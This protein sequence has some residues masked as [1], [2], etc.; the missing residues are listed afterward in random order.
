MQQQYTPISAFCACAPP[1]RSLLDQWERHLRLL[2]QAGRITVWSE[3]HL[4]AGMVRS[5]EID[6]HLEQADLILLLLSADFFA[7]D[8]CIALMERALHLHQAGKVHV[9]P[10]LLRSVEW[11]E[12]PLASLS[13]LPSNG[14]PIIEW[15]YPDAAFRACVRGILHVLGRPMTSALQN[16]NRTRMLRRLRRSYSDLLSQS[17]QGAA[18]MKL[19]L[20]QKPN[21]V[22]NT[23]TLLLQHSLRAE[24]LFPPGTSVLSAYDEAEHELLILGEAGAGKSTLL[25]NL[26]QQLVVRAEQD[27]AHPL[28]VILPLSS[29][30]TRQPQLQNWLSEQLMQ[31]YNVPQRLSEQWVQEDLILPLLDGLD[32]MD[33]TARPACIA[34]I[35]DYHREHPVSLVVCSRRAEY[36]D[37]A[38]QQRL[39]LQSAVEVQ[40]LTRE[41]VDAYLIQAGEP[42]A[43]LRN[44]LEKYPFLQE[45]TTTPLMLSVL[46]LTY[47]ETPVLDRSGKD[48]LLQQQVWTDYVEQML[49]HG[50]TDT[51]YTHQDTRRWLAWLAKQL[52]QRSQTL[53]Y[54]ERMQPVWLEGQRVRQLYPCIVIGLIFGLLGFVG[55]GSIWAFIATIPPLNI[56]NPAPILGLALLSGFVEGSILGLVNGLLYKQD[57]ENVSTSEAQ[58]FRTARQ[59]VARSI[60]NGL[61]IGLIVGCPYEL[62]RQYNDPDVY[63][64]ILIIG[65][66][67]SIISGLV[68]GLIERLLDIQTTK[69]QPAEMFAWSWTS[70]GRGLVKFLSFGLLSPLLIGLLFGLLAQAFDENN[71][72]DNL[73]LG[74]QLAL[75]LVPFFA[76]LSLLGGLSAGLSSNILDESNI[77]TPNQGIR[78]SARYSVLVGITSIF[79]GVGISVLISVLTTILFKAPLSLSFAFI[80]GPL[81][82]LVSGLRVG[83][84]ACIQHVVLRWLLWKDKMMPWNYPRFLD[85]AARRILLRKVGGGYSFVHRLLLEYFATLDTTSTSQ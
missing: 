52:K 32:E 20:S 14:I 83:G 42:L 26:A 69:I 71:L 2:E 15:D 55:L 44:A 60:L 24:K 84:I 41:Q 27:E 58:R 16:Q 76:Q 72:S 82:G 8:E 23:I 21:A 39:T 7:D 65:I 50:R 56:N 19:G 17:L 79:V 81:I 57:T 43:A 12:S 5:Q 22:Q 10:L 75:A 67:V 78:L 35:N 64:G 33:A 4:S 30:A 1:D 46:I 18:W 11:Q 54:I 25:L 66:L 31:I 63:T 48:D 74:L 34:A 70:I 3:Q 51:R 9:I 45:L 49:E 6:V 85:Y 38:E 37:A 47:H 36:E 59:R 40:P 29:W 80:F 13:C 73:L 77:V 53:F 68:F 62:I 28:P 61:L